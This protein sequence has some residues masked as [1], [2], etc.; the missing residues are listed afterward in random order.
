M[1]LPLKAVLI[2]MAVLLV[3]SYWATVSSG[4][5]LPIGEGTKPIGD[6]L[7]LI[8][9]DVPQTWISSVDVKYWATVK[10]DSGFKPEIRRACFNFTDGKQSCVDVEANNVTSG[11][12]RVQIHLPAG[13]KKIDCYAEYIRDGKISRTNTITYHV[14]TLKKPEE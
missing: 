12:F 11:R 6:Q 3:I 13:T 8:S 2:K 1:K 7:K 9:M 4:W 5:D 14:I 10:F